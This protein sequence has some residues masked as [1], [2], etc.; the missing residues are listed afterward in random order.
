VKRLRESLGYT[1][2]NRFVVSVHTV[3]ER[4]SGPTSSRAELFPLIVNLLVGRA[5]QLGDHKGQEVAATEHPVPN[6]L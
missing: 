3:G 5:V 6:S 4:F 1:Q 2:G